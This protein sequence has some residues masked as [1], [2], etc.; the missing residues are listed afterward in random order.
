M[1][2]AKENDYDGIVIPA[3]KNSILGACTNRGGD[4][5]KLIWD[6]TLKNS[7]RQ[8]ETVSFGN[9]HVLTNG[10][11]SYSFSNGALIWKNN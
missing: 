5:P 3:D 1:D 8:A 6:K 7:K 10:K 4:F 9:K 11:F 2:F